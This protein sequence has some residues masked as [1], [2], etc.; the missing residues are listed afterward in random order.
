[1]N[2]KLLLDIVFIAIAEIGICLNAY[3][4]SV[5]FL[6]DEYTI[7]ISAQI[8]SAFLGLFVSIALLC[9]SINRICRRRK[10]KRNYLEE[11]KKRAWR[12][13]DEP[14]IIEGYLIDSRYVDRT[15]RRPEK[16]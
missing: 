14:I 3:F 1:M 4:L 5:F 15:Q 11:L 16:K 10:V 12:K 8:F 2:K 13:R 9:V 6:V 7:I